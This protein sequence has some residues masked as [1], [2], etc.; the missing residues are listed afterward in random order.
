MFNDS[1]NLSLHIVKI[2]LTPWCFNQSSNDFW[3]IHFTISFSMVR[4]LLCI[5]LGK[6]WD[7]LKLRIKSISRTIL[8]IIKFCFCLDCFSCSGSTGC[9]DP[10]NSLG[11]GVTTTG[12]ISGNIYCV[13]CFILETSNINILSFDL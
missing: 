4:V 6:L 10:F 2:W 13:V 11:P 3:I 12:S 9:S 7:F 1:L 8:V 5:C